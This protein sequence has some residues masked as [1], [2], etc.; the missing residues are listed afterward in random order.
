MPHGGNQPPPIG[1]KPGRGGAPGVGPRT[2]AAMAGF[3][4]AIWPA[5]SQSDSTRTA[6]R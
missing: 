6:A 3:A 1:R 2:V 4:G 5:I